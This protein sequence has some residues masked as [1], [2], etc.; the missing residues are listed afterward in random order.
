M[1]HAKGWAF[2]TPRSTQRDPSGFYKGPPKLWQE[3]QPTNQPT[4]HGHQSIRPGQTPR[5][6]QW[7]QLSS[8][9]GR[10]HRWL[11]T[12]GRSRCHVA[13]A[14]WHQRRWDVFFFVSPNVLKGMCLSEMSTKKGH[15]DKSWKKYGKDKTLGTLKKKSRAIFKIE[16]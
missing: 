16:H 12:T 7:L 10:P 13:T 9:C 3:N 6:Q 5:L 15:M 8:H 2:K 14:I 1:L 11:R 4:N